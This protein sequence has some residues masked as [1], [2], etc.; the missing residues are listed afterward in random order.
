[1]TKMFDGAIK[2]VH[3]EGITAANTV[4]PERYDISFTD[5]MELLQ[6]AHKG[7]AF[8]ALNLAFS[9]GFVMGN[10]CTL[11]RKLPRL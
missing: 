4:I 5:M 7:E 3:P 6:L 10:R 8:K 11:R 9:F 2:K 1:M